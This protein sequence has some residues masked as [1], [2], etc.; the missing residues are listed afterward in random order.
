MYAEKHS[1]HNR[2]VRWLQIICTALAL[3]Q[4]I[5]FLGAE[6]GLRWLPLGYATHLL[7]LFFSLISLLLVRNAGFN[8]RISSKGWALRSTLFQL[9]SRFIAWEEIKNV[10]FFKPDELPGD[11]NTKDFGYT[12]LISDPAYDVVCIELTNGFQ[13]FVSIRNRNNVVEFLHHGLLQLELKKKV[14]I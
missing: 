11:W 12:F 8:F 13:V 14:L 4:L 1:L 9:Q 5:A 2:Y 6:T 3:W 7:L 10:R